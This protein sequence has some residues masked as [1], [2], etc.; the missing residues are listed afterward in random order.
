VPG[1]AA[2]PF[3][4]SALGAASLNYRQICGADIIYATNKASKKV[5][6]IVTGSPVNLSAQDQ[7]NLANAALV[8]I[9]ELP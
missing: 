7:L 9:A 8:N 1:T 4:G 6:V 3:F 2:G 5:P